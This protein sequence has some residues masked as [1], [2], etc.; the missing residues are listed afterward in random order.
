MKKII[1]ILF[2]LFCFPFILHAQSKHTL[3]IKGRSFTLDGQPFFYTGISFFNAIYN[4][5]FNESDESRKMWL[6]KLKSN[7]INV[8]RVWAQW[9][10]ERGLI[11]TCPTCSLYEKDGRLRPQ[12]VNTLRKIIQVA[13]ELQMV[14]LFVLFQ[15]ENWDDNI[16]LSDEAS[17]KV[18]RALTADLKPYRNLVFQIWNEFDNRTLAY[19]KIIKDSD[20]TRLVTNSP[21]YGGFLGR[22]EEN[23]ALDFLSPHT[24]RRDDLQ[25]EIAPK[26]IAYLL[27]LYQKPVVDDEPARRGTPKF[28]GPK[29][30]TSPFDHILRIYNIWK[31]GGHVIYHHDMFQT[32][33]GSE[34]IPPSGIPDPDFSP[35]HRVV[36]D[37][38]ALK[39]RYILPIK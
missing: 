20:P 25:W 19:M 37:F 23:A 36:F 18:V 30:P 12:H 15:R 34:A 14:V 16:R 11:D 22:G 17:D 28:G 3:E 29:K 9:D 38:L 32:G 1:I 10:T 27:T 31:A 24:S 5:T 4:P 35:Y 33:Y 21:G 13:D 26:E 39:E 6:N 2:L 8:I 7:G